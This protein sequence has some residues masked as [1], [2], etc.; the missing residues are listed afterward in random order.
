MTAAIFPE[1]QAVV[2]QRFGALPDEAR[3]QRTA[4]ALEANNFRVL[5]A[6]NAAEARLRVLELLPAGAEVYQGASRTL[7]ELGIAGEIENS[8][9]FV[10]VR[11]RVWGMDRATQADEIRQ[12]TAAPEY[13]LGSVHAVTEGGVL[14]AV[15]AGG[16][17]LGPYVSGAGHLVLVVGTQ[18]IVADLDEAMQRINEYV[19]PL[20]DARALAAYGVHSSINKVLI[21]NREWAPGR[22]TVVLV[23]EALGF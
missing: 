20:E 4:E 15:S 14:V 10:A 7:D 12:L 2:S 9:R 21:L 19:F 16:S 22:V 23:D 8:G 18:K 5:R 13:M 1:L 17:Q 3:V 11:P 6:G